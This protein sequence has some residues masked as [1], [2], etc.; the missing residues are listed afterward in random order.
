MSEPA[1]AGTHT[2]AITPGAVDNLRCLI[3]QIRGGQ[4]LGSFCRT[5]RQHID[6]YDWGWFAPEGA[7][8][9]RHRARLFYVAIAR[10]MYGKQRWEQVRDAGFPLLIFHS[11]AD[12]PPPHLALDGLTLT[13]DHPFWARYRPPLNGQCG[14]YVS[15]ARS[16]RGA[17]RLGGRPDVVLPDWWNDADPET[18]VPR[19]VH[20]LWASAAGP[21]PLTLLA[22]IVDDAVVDRS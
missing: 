2:F 13:S 7:D 11:D 17:A 5:F 20:P 3:E 15:G 14:C 9:F 19:G 16:S 22:A 8:Q 4:S 1:D 6:D 21:D 10:L 12:C 18:G